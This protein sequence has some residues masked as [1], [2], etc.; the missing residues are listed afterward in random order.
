[1]S[2][3]LADSLPALQTRFHSWLRDRVGALI[4]KHQ[5]QLPDLAT[6]AGKPE[7]NGNHFPIPGMYGGFYYWLEREGA[8]AQLMVLSFSRIVGGSEPFYEITVGGCRLIAG[9]ELRVR[10]KFWLEKDSPVLSAADRN[11]WRPRPA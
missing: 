11:N 10:E 1:M 5:L 8:D 7:S 3:K 9:A 6:L 2:D 4:E